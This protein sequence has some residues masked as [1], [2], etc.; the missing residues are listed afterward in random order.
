M[1]TTF[2]WPWRNEEE[3]L[4]VRDLFYPDR[5]L[6][7]SAR[8]EKQQLAVNVVSHMIF[9]D[10]FIQRACRH[11]S[12]DYVDLTVGLGK[13]VETTPLP[14]TAFYRCDGRLGRCNPA[15]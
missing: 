8:R 9:N 13:Y 4:E 1:V 10:N 6:D 5:Q 14:H 3:L 12:E 2:V 15:P 11:W 7:G